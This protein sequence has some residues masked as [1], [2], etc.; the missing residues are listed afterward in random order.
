MQKIIL[1]IIFITI[2][3]IGAGFN[4]IPNNTASKNHITTSHTGMTF[5]NKLSSGR[6]III[7]PH[8]GNHYNISSSANISWR[9]AM[10]H[11]AQKCV[12]IKLYTQ[13][14]TY[15][16]LIKNKTCSQS[17]KWQIPHDLTGKK[18]KIKIATIDGKIIKY[19]Q[20]FFIDTPDLQ[21]KKSDINIIPTHPNMGENIKINIDV[22][23]I[24]LAPADK[25]DAK[26]E[27]YKPDNTI[28]L[29]KTESIG[30][31]RQNSKSKIT[32]YMTLDDKYSGKYKLKINLNAKNKIPESNKHNN[33]I[34]YYFLVKSLPNL[35]V[36]V[37]NGKRPRPFKKATI[38]AYVLNIG[39]KTSSPC[40]LVFSVRDDYYPNYHKY[41]RSIPSIRPRGVYSSAHIRYKWAEMSNKKKYFYVTVDPTNSVKEVNDND[42]RASGFYYLTRPGGKHGAKNQVSCS[43]FGPAPV[44]KSTVGIK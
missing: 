42:N 2:T 1:T 40:K 31:I 13:G 35:V 26:I 6:I 33:K 25:S 27:I 4:Y 38:R 34:T 12:S 7:S 5:G 10:G 19:S 17:F 29:S 23:N 22:H 28:A 30:S 41:E 14:G 32:L 21:V 11:V 36:C 37:D 15:T 9:F 16:R 8:A 24:G 39:K 43:W 44:Q 18:Y 20:N 3:L